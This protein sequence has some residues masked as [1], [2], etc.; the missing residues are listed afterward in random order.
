M[1]NINFRKFLV[2]FAE[3]NQES[4]RCVVFVDAI[5]KKRFCEWFK[6]NASVKVLQGFLNYLHNSTN[7]PILYFFPLKGQKRII[8]SISKNQDLNDIQRNLDQNCTK[9]GRNDRLENIDKSQNRI[10]IIYL[11]CDANK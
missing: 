11:A 10:V 1:E 9:L 3:I 2:D 8:D 5:R 6:K 4:T 7:S